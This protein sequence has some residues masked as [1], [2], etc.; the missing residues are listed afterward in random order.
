MGVKRALAEPASTQEPVQPE[1]LQWYVS[2]S[3]STSEALTATVVGSPGFTREGE[4]V[5]RATRGHVFSETSMSAPPEPLDGARTGMDTV[6]AAT[7]P[8]GSVT[9]TVRDT[10]PSAEGAVHVVVALEGEPNVPS[11]PVHA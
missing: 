4:A 7:A 8:C 6:I 10:R 5:M 1:A 3:P 11:A 9:V 2:V